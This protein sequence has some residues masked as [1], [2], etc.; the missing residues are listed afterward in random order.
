MM[1][2]S[3]A[4]GRA[5]S[6]LEEI[7]TAQGGDAATVRDPSRL[8]RAHDEATFQAKR[9]GIVERV[10]PRAIGYGIIALGGGRRSMEDTIDP[11]VGFV[12]SAKPGVRV[13][14]G[15]TLARI[16]ARNKEGL[17]LGKSILEEAIEIGDSGPEVLPL[18]SHRVTAR[19]VEELT[20]TAVKAG[21]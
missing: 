20:E 16:Y 15:Q 12:V 7:V 6:K 5:L 13:E 11:S 18:I 17:E 4:S 19:G 3:I 1:D 9:A 10:D 14:K 2:D 21:G 8:P